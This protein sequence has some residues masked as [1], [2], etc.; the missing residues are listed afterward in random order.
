MQPTKASILEAHGAK[1][2]AIGFGTMEFPGRAAE[3]VTHAINVGYRHIDTARKYGTEEQVGDG[4][5]ASGIARSELFVTTKVTELDARAADFLRSAET[6]LKT[7]KLDYVDLLLIHWP[8]PNVP[9]TETLGALAKAKRSGM[10]RHIGV[11][12]FT[13]AMLEEAVRVCPEPLVTNQIEYHAYLRQDRM[14]AALK[15][16]GMILTAYC[17]V[18]RGQLLDDPVIGEIA[19][20]HG[21]THAQICLRWLIQ[22]PMVAAVPRAL[23]ETHIV[24]NLDV[25]GFSLSDEEMR[26]IS[27]L[28]ARNVRI[29]DP[30]ERAPKWDVETV[31]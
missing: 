15:R 26:R 24:E 6:S 30:P 27:V 23:E 22:Q 16:H 18:A 31:A 17:P 11:S 28:R 14:I 5:R 4:I 7:L 10:T 29:A 2:P 1:M 3:L 21:K 12:N 19:K 9:F 13:L 25:F 8:Q 20:A